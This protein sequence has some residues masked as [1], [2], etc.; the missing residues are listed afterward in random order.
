MERESHW[1][2]Y[3]VCAFFFHILMWVFFTVALPHLAASI[4]IPQEEELIVE[5]E[6]MQPEGVPDAPETP[7]AEIPAPEPEPMI[8]DTIPPE[9]VVEIPLEDEAKEVAETEEEAVAKLK[10]DEKEGKEST[11]NVAVRG[12]SNGQTMGEPAKLIREVQPVKGSISFK[13]RISVSAHINK[14]G[15]VVDTKIMISSGNTLYDNVAMN[16]VKKQWKFKPATDVKGEPME[17]NYICSLYFNVSQHR[18]N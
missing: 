8:E 7:P 3:Y 4:E 17:S 6:D 13:G 18:K 12:N 2:L 1:R 9:E 10:Q 16:I 11:G 14:K 5:I 15:E